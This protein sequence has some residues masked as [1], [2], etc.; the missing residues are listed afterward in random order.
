MSSSYVSMS[1]FSHAPPPPPPTLLKLLEDELEELDEI[2]IAE[3]L[4][5]LDDEKLL[6]LDSNVLN[7]ASGEAN[8][9]T[10]NHVTPPSGVM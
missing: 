5:L 4:E 6:L 10:L 3:L 2:E 9:G 7:S 1:S 8:G